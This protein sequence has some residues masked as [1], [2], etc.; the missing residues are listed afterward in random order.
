VGHLRSTDLN[1]LF[2]DLV[3]TLM[4]GFSPGADEGGN[5]RTLAWYLKRWGSAKRSVSLW[6]R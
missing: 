2:T 1:A 6:E 3:E 5:R 4:S